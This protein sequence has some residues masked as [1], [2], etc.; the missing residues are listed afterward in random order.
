MLN[1]PQLAKFLRTCL[2]VL[3]DVLRCLG[4]EIRHESRETLL[5]IA[6]F[7]WITFRD[8]KGLNFRDELLRHPILFDA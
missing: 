2:R 6:Q 4:P 3:L 5:E 8:D 7:S 1:L